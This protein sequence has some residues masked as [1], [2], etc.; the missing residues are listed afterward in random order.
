MLMLNATYSCVDGEIFIVTKNHFPLSI[1]L[2]YNYGFI[3]RIDVMS[4][5]S[6]GGSARGV[7][8]NATATEA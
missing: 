5:L 3:T 1:I 7:M 6:N 8:H 2:W 4:Y